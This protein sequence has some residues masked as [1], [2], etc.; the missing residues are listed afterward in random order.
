MAETGD[1]GD[2]F[3]RV[4]IGFAPDVHEWLR[5]QAFRRRTTMAQIVRDAVEQHRD[6]LEPQLGLPFDQKQGV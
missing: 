2:R 6:R 4:P 3:V 1:T 5:E